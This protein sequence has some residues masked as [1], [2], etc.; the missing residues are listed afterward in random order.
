M[1]V[2]ARE[3]VKVNGNKVSLRHI[4]KD[5]DSVEIISAVDSREGDS[6]LSDITSEV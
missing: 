6:Q 5:G 1:A 2:S 4:L 3:L